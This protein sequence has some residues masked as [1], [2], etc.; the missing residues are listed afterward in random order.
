[1]PPLTRGVEKVTNVRARWLGHRLHAELNVAVSSH[2]SVVDA[3]SVAKEVRHQLL[4]KLPHLSSVIVHV[5]PME[6]PGE[7]F[8][9][10]DQHSH[11][12]LPVHSH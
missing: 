1:M 10:I 3:H 8:H 4:H 6:E 12:G 7:E 11:D 9:R 5:D 2:L